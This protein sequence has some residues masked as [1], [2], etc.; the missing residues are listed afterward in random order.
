MCM[1]PIFGFFTLGM[2]TGYTVYFPEI[3]PTHLR[4]LGWILFQYGS[5]GH[6]IRNTVDRAAVTSN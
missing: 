4:G 3:Y 2:H 6:G 1:L 5:R